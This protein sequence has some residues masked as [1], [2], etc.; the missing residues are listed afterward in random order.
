[1]LN[2]AHSASVHPKYTLHF[3][4]MLKVLVLTEED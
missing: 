3:G 4:M 1:M 2:V